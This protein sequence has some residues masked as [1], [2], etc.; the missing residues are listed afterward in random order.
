MGG[1]WWFAQTVN[2]EYR[3]F[4][5]FEQTQSHVF[6]F[7]KAE[8]Q[9]L[10]VNGKRNEIVLN[11]IYYDIAK[12]TPQ[13]TKLRVQCTRDKIDTFLAFL[14]DFSKKSIDSSKFNSKK[15]KYSSSIFFFEHNSHTFMYLDCSD[16]R[17]SIHLS[18]KKWILCE[19]IFHPPAIWIKIS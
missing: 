14:Q 8:L 13:G 5:A 12:Q 10:R 6:L 1:V 2:Y 9:A 3:L 11:G 16:A 15:Y 17:L 4:L 18:L 19:D 7:E